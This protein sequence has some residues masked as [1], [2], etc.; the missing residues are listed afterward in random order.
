MDYSK[1]DGI[2]QYIHQSGFDIVVAATYPKL[3]DR[4]L[5]RS[6]VRAEN[7]R[8]VYLYCTAPKRISQNILDYEVPCDGGVI[9]ICTN[10]LNVEVAY[11]ELISALSSE[12]GVV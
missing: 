7:L 10:R 6:A 11:N 12:S 3:A 1:I 2:V 9:S 8:E 4:V 5:I